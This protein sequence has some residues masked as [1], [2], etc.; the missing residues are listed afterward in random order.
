MC[1]AP[2][3]AAPVSTSDKADCPISNPNVCTWTQKNYEGTLSVS[4]GN[5]GVCYH[6]LTIRSFKVSTPVFYAFYEGSNCTG[7]YFVSKGSSADATT[8]GYVAHSYK[9]R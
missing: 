4:G 2:A 7:R 9:A 1:I 3:T 6:G 5:P 8:H